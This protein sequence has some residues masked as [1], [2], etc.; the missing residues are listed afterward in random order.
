VSHLL[1]IAEEL[2]FSVYLATLKV[3]RSGQADEEYY[4]RKRERSRK[5]KRRSR[6]HKDWDE[7]EGD[8]EEYEEAEGGEPTPTMGK[9]EIEN[10][11]LSNLVVLCGESRL[12]F[13]EFVI[14]DSKAVIPKGAFDGVEPDS[15]RTEYE[16]GEMGDVRVWDLLF[17]QSS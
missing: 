14:S 15:Y 13:D 5:R 7:L 12:P 2:G 10:Y 11:E 8:D 3:T 9:P 6:W 4:R 1:P 17:A 16:D